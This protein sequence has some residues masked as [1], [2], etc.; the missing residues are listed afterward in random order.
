[1]L[2][3]S[4]EGA[5]FPPNE[6]KSIH[7]VELTYQ[8]VMLRAAFPNQMIGSLVTASKHAERHTEIQYF[9]DVEARF[10]TMYPLGWLVKFL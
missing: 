4:R 5:S 6:A 8:H 10:G 9:D 1:M 3:R 2:T 7:S